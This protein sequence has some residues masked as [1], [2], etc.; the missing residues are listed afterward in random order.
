[1]VS[2]PFVYYQV[3]VLVGFDGDRLIWLLISEPS[4]PRSEDLLLSAGTSTSVERNKLDESATDLLLYRI[5][6]RC[7]AYPHF[8]YFSEM[9]SF[10]LTFTSVHDVD[11][12]RCGATL[13]AVFSRF[14]RELFWLLNFPRIAHNFRSMCVGE[15]G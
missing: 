10:L 11:L 9:S 5:C 2:F 15:R 1:M 3:L 12:G 14:S 4:H 13:L 8:G 6:P 7:L